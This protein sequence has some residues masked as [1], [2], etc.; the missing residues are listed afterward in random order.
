MLYFGSSRRYPFLPFPAKNI[1][2]A[3]L[4]L[5]EEM[6]ATD[7]SILH[8]SSRNCFFPADSNNW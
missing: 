3:H 4:L 7:F 8:V 5:M 6:R 1:L 2:S